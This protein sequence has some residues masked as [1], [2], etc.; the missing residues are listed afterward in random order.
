MNNK[1]AN[2]SANE[3]NVVD[4]SKE[5][6]IAVLGKLEELSAIAAWSVHTDPGK[7][8]P[9]LRAATL[10]RLRDGIQWVSQQLESHL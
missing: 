7:E 3:S 5:D 2:V 8:T 9:E 4:V 1:Q 6:L 10:S